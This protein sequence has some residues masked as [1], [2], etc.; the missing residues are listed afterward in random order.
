MANSDSAR[1]LG[2]S[3]I[4]TR[5]PVVNGIDRRPA[6]S[7]VRSL[8][9]GTLSGDPKWGPPFALSRSED[10][11]SMIPMDALTCF[12]RAMSSQ[13]MT[14]G[15]RWGRSPVSSMTRMEAARR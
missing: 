2:V 3:P 13:L 4:P 12:N 10:V 5:I 8:T 7:I 1:S 11:S 9:S 14:P 15:F 6:S